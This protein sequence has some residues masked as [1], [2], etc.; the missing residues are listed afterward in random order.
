MAGLADLQAD[1]IKAR[2]RFSNEMRLKYGYVLHAYKHIEV[3]K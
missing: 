2:Q 3:E 1:K